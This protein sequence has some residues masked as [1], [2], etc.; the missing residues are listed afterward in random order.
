MASVGV[1]RSF[2]PLPGPKPVHVFGSVKARVKAT[3]L[4]SDIVDTRSFG[5]GPKSGIVVRTVTNTTSN[6]TREVL[7]EIPKKLTITYSQD[8]NILSVDDIIRK[9][10]RQEKYTR[11]PLLKKQLEELK[12]IANKVQTYI[13]RLQT[14]EMIRDI[15]Q[16]ILK[17]ESGM[18]ITDYD[19]VVGEYLCEYRKFDNHVKTRVF[20]MDDEKFTFQDLDE[21]SR[22]RIYLIDAYLNI[23]S[24]YIEIEVNRINCV[25]SDACI[26]C[27]TDLAMI[28]PS[29]EGCIRCPN[30]ECLTEH[31]MISMGKSSKDNSR[32]CLNTSEDESIENFLRAFIRYQGMQLD[33]PPDSLYD[34]LD[35]YFIMQGLPTGEEISGLP[36]NDRG[37]RGNTNPKMLWKAL[38]E[39]GR[40]EYYE[41]A[42]LIGKLYWGWELPDIMMFRETIVD[43]YNK[44]Q[45]VFYEI[46]SEERCRTSSLGTQYRLWRHLQL[47]GHDCHMDEFKIAENTD[48][49]RIH[50]KLWRL[51]CE[52]TNDPAIYYIQ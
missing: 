41:D 25:Q 15:E 42:N 29:E 5:S 20:G 28:A 4:G 6:T 17:I 51:M 11:L 34:E 39:I 21:E 35:D 32:I 22:R 40:A 31:T 12:S 30:P 16:D 18:N 27:G 38:S 33:G 23:A 26:V 47:V 37:R 10:L 44:T 24:R 13:S 43:H 2:V 19:S 7:E 48:S 45:K 14:M 49:L 52:G 46:P 50:N 8:Y 9:K 3:I 36:L 1:A